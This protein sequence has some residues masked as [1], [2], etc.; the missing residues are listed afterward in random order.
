M[1]TDSRQRLRKRSI[2]MKQSPVVD[3]SDR[4]LPNVFKVKSGNELGKGLRKAS[5]LGRKVERVRAMSPECKSLSLN[6]EEDSNR[7]K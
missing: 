3:F 4:K 6:E 2:S 1:R 5:E 7:K